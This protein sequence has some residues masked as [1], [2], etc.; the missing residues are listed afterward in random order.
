M[1]DALTLVRR[2]DRSY[3]FALATGALAAASIAL[4]D[5]P[6]FRG[7]A[8]HAG[9]YESARVPTLAELQ[10][11][12][13]TRGKVVS[14][15]AVVAGIVYIGSSDQT[16]YALDATTGAVRWRYATGGG[17]E[18][19]PAV[20]D[21]TV[22]ALSRDGSLHAVDSTTGALRWKFATEGERRFTAAGIH[23]AKPRTEK[24]P[25]PFDT[26]LSS[27]TVVRGVV[28]FG[29]GDR[30]VY[31][32]DANTGALRW[33]FRTGDVVHATPAVANGTVYIGSWDRRMYALDARTGVPMWTF[34]TG[35][36]TDIYNQT[37]IAG[38]AAISGDTVFFGCRDGHLYAV[39]ARRGTLRWSHDTHKGWVIASPAVARGVVYFPTSDGQRFKALDAVTGATIHDFANKAVSFSSPAIVDDTA[40]YGTSDGLLHAVDTTTGKFVAQFQTDGAKENGARY[41]DAEGRIDSAKI[42]SGFTLDAMIVGLERMYTLG[43][44]LSSPVVVDGT[45]YFGSTD[46][47]VYAVR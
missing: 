11:K 5:A 30:H 39:D 47:N 37:G 3:L 6:M 28:Y 16:L 33:K 15:P 17:V 23:G 21:G 14:S 1:H 2:P 8:A 29:S 32:V 9:I 44:I 20:A 42:Y 12:F 13:A 25:D 26:F 46:G 36:D 22:F 24:M 41:L 4:A 35:E 7:D 43:S 31:A 34:E 10:W 27:P 38:S 19:S 18:S 45:V 40:F